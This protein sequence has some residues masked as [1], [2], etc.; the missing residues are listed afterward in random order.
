MSGTLAAEGRR[1]GGDEVAEPTPP[2]PTS[3]ADP[4]GLVPSTKSARNV[5]ST[6][7]GLGGTTVC[8]TRAD[9]LS[10][11]AEFGPSPWTSL[12]EDSPLPRLY[13]TP[14]ALIATRTS[15]RQLVRQAEFAQLRCVSIANAAGLFLADD[16]DW[17]PKGVPAR[18]VT[19]WSPRSR[20]NMV[21][22][23]ASLDWSPV[24]ALAELGRIPAMVT[25]TYPGE[26]EVVAPDGKTVKRQVRT[27]Q[28]RYRRAWGEPVIG[29]WKLE[30]QHRGAPH[31]HI[32]MAPPHGAARGRGVGA[33][34]SF[35]YWLSV[36][37]A[38]IVD[39][40]DPVEYQKHL[41]A[42]TG[43]D[44][45][46]AL[47]CI[48]PKRLAVY[49]GKHGQ[50]RDKEY[51]HIVPEPWQAPGKGPGRFW[52]YWQVK[53]LAV[54]VEMTGDDYQLAARIMRRY[55]ERIRVWDKAAGRWRYTRAMVP[56]KGRWRDV[57]PD[58]GE[59]VWRKHRRRMR[60]RRL[61]ESGSGFLIVNDG[62]AM[63]RQLARA[64]QVCGGGR[65]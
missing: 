65:Q 54:A 63:A 15:S 2:P 18:Q 29:A 16:P 36:V 53:P 30:F 8:P 55:S 48:D 51:Q 25:L 32:F 43:V 62:P 38:D 28:D 4:P 27:W 42:G 1:V 39:H 14:G 44:Y 9:V 61:A 52:G 57:D 10:A 50:Y 33:G 34:M 60:A 12:A 19:S 11:V 24:Y 26:W 37:W 35:R 59:V 49:F 7:A 64:L 17:R 6:L 3:L 31:I 45:A 47:K 56:V 40:P 5:P 41:A 13:V 20:S 58:T 22:T 46:E 23:F 21:K